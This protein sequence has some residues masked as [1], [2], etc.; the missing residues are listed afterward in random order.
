[1]PVTVNINTK[2]YSR[3][4][5]TVNDK[6]F[7]I[8]SGHAF[9]YLDP[10]IQQLY[11]SYPFIEPLGGFLSLIEKNIS[12]LTLDGLIKFAEIASCIKKCL[13][14]I[15]YEFPDTIT[16]QQELFFA[17]LRSLVYINEE[18]ALFKTSQTNYNTINDDG[19]T[20]IVPHEVQEILDAVKRW[21]LFSSLLEN[22]E[23]V[24]LSN[25][26]EFISTISYNC[27]FVRK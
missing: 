17:Q 12:L 1:M 13:S 21:P 11:F 8:S 27:R 20:I 5:N 22:N 9:D 16:C 18:V 3:G 25:L 19:M 7:H 4:I 2:T 24:P 26:S 15:E 10:E 14:G 6:S 23:Y